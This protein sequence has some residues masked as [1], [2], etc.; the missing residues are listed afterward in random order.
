MSYAVVALLCIAVSFLAVRLIHIKHQLRSVSEQMEENEHEYI[1]V[2]FV[3]KD[4]EDVVLRINKNVDLLQRTKAQ[5]GQVEHTDTERSQ[6]Q[7]GHQIGGNCRERQLL[8]QTGHQKT[9]NDTN[10]DLDK[11]HFQKNHPLFFK[12]SYH[13]STF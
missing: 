7:A 1:C 5:A 4:I 10:S 12:N 9:A 11:Q 3:D 2:D 8:G 6:N 13:H